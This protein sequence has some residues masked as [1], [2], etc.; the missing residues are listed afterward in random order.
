MVPRTAA[1]VAE[2]SSKCAR[3]SCSMCGMC[4]KGITECLA[5]SVKWARNVSNYKKD[6]VVASVPNSR[7]IYIYIYI[8]IYVYISI[9]T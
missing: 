5:R 7:L 6:N 9:F 4:D 2:A 1:H 3:R 8:Y